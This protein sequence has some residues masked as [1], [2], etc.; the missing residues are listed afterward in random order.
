MGCFPTSRSNENNSLTEKVFTTRRGAGVAGSRYRLRRPKCWQS[1]LEALCECKNRRSANCD[2]IRRLWESDETVS[3]LHYSGFWRVSKG[4]DVQSQPLSRSTSAENSLDRGRIREDGLVSRRHGHGSTEDSLF[5]VGICSDAITDVR[6]PSLGVP[7]DLGL[8]LF[9]PTPTSASKPRMTAPGHPHRA[10]SG[11]FVRY[12][13]LPARFGCSR[14]RSATPAPRRNRSAGRA[15]GVGFQEWIAR[16]RRI[17][18]PVRRNEPETGPRAP[19]GACA[20]RAIRFQA[21]SRDRPL[22]S[23]ALL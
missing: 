10:L 3:G 2:T 20:A 16:R 7:L 1:R 12:A 23:A 6:L 9:P 5:H 21:P 15:S 18:E 14:P 17:L 4:R 13:R 11:Q 19:A 8:V 22:S